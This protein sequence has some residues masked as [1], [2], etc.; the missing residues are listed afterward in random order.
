MF[1]LVVV[2]Y[3]IAEGHWLLAFAIFVFLD[4]RD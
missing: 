3:C 4:E 1:K 2:L